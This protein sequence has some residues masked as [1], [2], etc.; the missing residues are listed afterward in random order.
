MEDNKGPAAARPPRHPVVEDPF[1]LPI[2]RLYTFMT[3]SAIVFTLISLC[4]L[5]PIVGD[6]DKPWNAWV[7]AAIWAIAPPLWFA[8]ENKQLHTHRNELPPGRAD[9][10]RVNQEIARSF[11]LGLSVIVLLLMI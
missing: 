8:V 11:W 5:C 10:I 1:Q 7:I 4:S 9:E 6:D 2:S 3:T